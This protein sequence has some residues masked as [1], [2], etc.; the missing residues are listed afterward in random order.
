MDSFHLAAVNPLE[1]FLKFR[2]Q[3]V[4][5]KTLRKILHVADMWRH[6]SSIAASETSVSLIIRFCF[7]FCFV[8]VFAFV[9]VFVRLFMIM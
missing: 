6:R 4:F 5:V 7:C 3:L 9:F 2:H 1:R 8:F